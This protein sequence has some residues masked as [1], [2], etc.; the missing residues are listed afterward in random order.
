M[1][2]GSEVCDLLTRAW[3]RRFTRSPLANSAPSGVVDSLQG[4]ASRT[5]G[6]N[7]PWF[8]RTKRRGI[9]QTPPRQRIVRGVGGGAV[10]NPSGDEPARSAIERRS[11]S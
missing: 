2:K 6:G 3:G 1:K 5:L 10:A 7:L 9:P 11:R 4:F 8:V